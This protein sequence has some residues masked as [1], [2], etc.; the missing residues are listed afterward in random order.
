MLLPSI[1]SHELGGALGLLASIFT[2]PIAGLDL[3]CL[4]LL[5]CNSHRDLLQALETVHHSGLRGL[6]LRRSTLI[7][8]LQ[9]ILGLL[10]RITK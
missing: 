1:W 8:L 3:L 2:L 5:A 6:L 4:L 10:A 9:Y 7:K